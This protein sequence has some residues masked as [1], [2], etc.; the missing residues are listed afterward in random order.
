MGMFEYIAVLTSI[1]IGLGIAHLLQG[2]ARLVQHPGRERVY[3]VHLTWVAYMFLLSVFWW[4]WEFRLGEIET[5]TF[6][7]YIFVIAYAVNMYLLCALLFPSDL[8]GYDGYEAYFFSRRRWFFALASLSFLVDLADSALKGLD[9]LMGLGV[10]YLVATPL[11][12]VLLV[13]AALTPSRAYHQTLAV[14][15]L[16]Y[17]VWWAVSSFGVMG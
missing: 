14:G 15:M 9:H 17:Q 2:V 4:W 10:E 11:Q 1:I 13:F 3:W 7:L 5:W 12:A 6:G 8:E 16:L